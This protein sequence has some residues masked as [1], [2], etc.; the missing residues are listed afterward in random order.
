M[1]INYI[2]SFATLVHWVDLHWLFVMD[3]SEDIPMC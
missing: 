3:L 1:L 2:V